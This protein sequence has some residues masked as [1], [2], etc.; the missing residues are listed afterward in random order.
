MIA[1]DPFLEKGDR[2]NRWRYTVKK[3][4]AQAKE[5]MRMKEEKGDV[6][7]CFF[8]SVGGVDV[9]V[10]GIKRLNVYFVCI[11]VASPAP[12]PSFVC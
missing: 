4:D 2:K 12:S 3:I 9:E 8:F 5:K 7:L 10:G 11:H 6:W 1:S